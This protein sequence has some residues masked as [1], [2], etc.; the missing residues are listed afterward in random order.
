MKKLLFIILFGFTLANYSQEHLARV[1]KLNGIEVY[2]MNEPL[3]AYE[4]VYDKGAGLNFT[5]FLTGGLINN[6]ISTRINKFVNGVLKKAKKEGKHIDAIIYS[7]GKNVIAIK[8]TEEATPENERLARVRRIH[9][10]PVY[11]M[12]DPVDKFKIV[13]SKGGGIK[14]KSAVTG[15]LINNSIEEDLEKFARKFKKLYNQGKIDAIY[16]T[17]GKKCEGIKFI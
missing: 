15:G 7:G 2:I 17:S 10:I 3:R 6:S 11:V 16:Y 1:Y 4:I 13:K 9:G 5:S 14:V 8:F 12:A